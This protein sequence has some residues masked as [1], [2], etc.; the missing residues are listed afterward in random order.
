MRTS[1]LFGETLKELPSS[2]EAE[3]HQLLLRAGYVRQ[4][5]AGIF[6]ALPLAWR[7][8]RKIEQVLREEMDRIGGQELNMPVVHPSDVWKESGRWDVIG[9]E[10]V[11]FKDR[12]D[13]DMLLAMTHEEVVGALAKSEVRSYKQLPILVYQMQTK[14]RDEPRAR[15]G[16]PRSSGLGAAVPRALPLLLPHRQAPRPAVGRGE[17]RLGDDGRQGRPRVHVRHRHR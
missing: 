1:N 14:F 2:V 6:S 12:K 10:M 5:A 17:E 7:S 8:L 11:R 13:R 15:G 16:R 3:S 9:P 4:L